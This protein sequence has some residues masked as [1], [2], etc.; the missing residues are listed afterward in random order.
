MYA[1]LHEA[2]IQGYVLIMILL[3]MGFKKDLVQGPVRGCYVN[4]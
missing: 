2:G 1:T 3:R 4:W